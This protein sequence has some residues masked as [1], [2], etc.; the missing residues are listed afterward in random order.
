MAKQSTDV[1]AQT[2]VDIAAS[3]DAQGN[4]YAETD[5]PLVSGSFT[6]AA[7]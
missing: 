1:C 7:Q 6:S 2:A 3:S 5:D 4:E